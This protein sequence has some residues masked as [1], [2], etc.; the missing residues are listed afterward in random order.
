MGDILDV[1]S[2]GNF[3][4]A[5]PG[6][7]KATAFFLELGYKIKAKKENTETKSPAQFIT[8]MLKFD[9][10]S[11]D[12]ASLT[13]GGGTLLPYGAS[14]VVSLGFNYQLAEC[15]YLQVFYEIHMEEDDKNPGKPGAGTFENIGASLGKDKYRWSIS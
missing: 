15:A 11:C 10:L 2:D 1:D 13:P 7:A 8:P 14:T 9:Y 5:G 6:E 3:E 12:A 4:E